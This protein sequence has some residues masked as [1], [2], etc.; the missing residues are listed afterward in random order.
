MSSPRTTRMF[1]LIAALAL[2]STACAT[3]WSAWGNGPERQGNNQFESLIGPN[4]ASQLHHLWSVN[5]GGYIN[6][7]PIEATGMPVLGAKHDL[8][9][10]GTERGEF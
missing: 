7:A 3:D 9:Y 5:L 10:V 8:L 1:V 6:A 4:N 2:V